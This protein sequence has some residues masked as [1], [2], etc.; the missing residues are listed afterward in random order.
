MGFNDQEIAEL[1]DS[2]DHLGSDAAP[3]IRRWIGGLVD[4]FQAVHRLNARSIL[5]SKSSKEQARKP[6]P[7]RSP[8][9]KQQR[10]GWRGAHYRAT[11]NQN[12]MESVCAVRTIQKNKKVGCAAI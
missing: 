11:S 7:D 9:E 2:D 5:V 6:L 10:V 1:D 4:H 3:A 12:C 8:T